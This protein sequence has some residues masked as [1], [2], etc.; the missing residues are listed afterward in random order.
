[1]KRKTKVEGTD[2]KPRLREGEVDAVIAQLT[3]LG[4]KRTR[5]GMERYGIPPD[6]ALG[7]PVGTLQ[8]LAKQLGKNHELARALWDTGV[9]EARMLAAYVDEPDRVTS[10]QMDRWCNAF[11]SWAICDTVCFV[12][13]DRTPH[14][15][16]K[17]V[18]WSG[19]R[20]EF[21][22]R[23]AFALLACLALHDKRA[24]DESFMR[25]LPLLERAAAD[26]RNFVKKAVS[27]A[28]R[29]IGRRSFALHAATAETARRLAES[30]L[31]TERWVGKDALRDLLR[32]TVTRR[33][34]SKKK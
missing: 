17:V 1:M 4:T 30:T 11:D 15:W 7:V 29:S 6:N 13:F 23:G 25:C 34:A 8:K 5:D 19:R 2:G 31:P 3:K 27:W 18:Q 14:A 22:K 21:A 10:S 9:Y 26:G 20:D 12:L 32:P 16:Q 28:L 24:G 33:L